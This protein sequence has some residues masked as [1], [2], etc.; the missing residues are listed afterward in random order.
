MSTARHLKHNRPTARHER[1]LARST[2]SNGKD[3]EIHGLPGANAA[4]HRH[5]F[6]VVFM[7]CHGAAC[8]AAKRVSSPLPLGLAT[9]S[10]NGSPH[11]RQLGDFCHFTD[12]TLREPDWITAGVARP[13]SGADEVAQ[14][15]PRGLCKRA[16]VAY[17]RGRGLSSWPPWAFC[18]P[19]A[20]LAKCGAGSWATGVA[21]AT[22][23]SP[24][25][26]SDLGA[27]R[28]LTFVFLTIVTSAAMLSIV[29]AAGQQ[30]KTHCRP[31]HCVVSLACLACVRKLA[32]VALACLVGMSLMG[33]VHAADHSCTSDA[34]CSYDGCAN[35]PCA[36][37]MLPH[38]SC[39]NGVWDHFCGDVRGSVSVCAHKYGSLEGYSCPEPS[40]CKKNHYSANG[41]DYLGD[42]ACQPCANGTYSSSGALSCSQS[43]STKADCD[44]SG[45]NNIQCTSDETSCIT[46][47]NSNLGLW[48]YD[49]AAVP[50]ANWLPICVYGHMYSEVYHGICPG[51]PLCAAGHYS[52]LAPSG[53]S[54]C[55]QCT[56]AAGSFCAA[57][58][59][60]AA[61]SVCPVG[62]YCLG[63][64]SDKQ[65]CT[66]AAGRFCPAGSSSAAGALCPAGH[67]CAGG[68]SDKQS[69]TTAPGSYCAA[70]S[71][72]AA[73]VLCPVGHFCVGGARDK[74]NCTAPV[75]SF[76]AE[77]SSSGYGKDCPNGHYCEGGVSDKRV[78]GYSCNSNA[79]CNYDGCSDVPC[80]SLSWHCDNGVR[81]VQCGSFGAKKYCYYYL[82]DT[83]YSEF[84]PKP[85]GAAGA[86]ITPAPA[87]TPRPTEPVTE[88]SQSQEC[89]F[90][91]ALPCTF[92]GTCG[93][94]FSADADGIL[95]RQGSCADQAGTLVLVNQGI[96]SLQPGVFGGMTKVTWISLAGNQLET[97]P[98]GIFKE[99]VALTQIWLY[100][101][102]LSS[103]PADIFSHIPQLTFLYLRAPCSTGAICG[104][105]NPELQCLPMTS[106]RRAALTTY[107]GP[108]CL[109]SNRNSNLQCPA[110]QYQSVCN[111]SSSG[112]CVTCGDCKAGD[113]LISRPAT[114]SPYHVKIKI[115]LPLPMAEFDDANQ[116]R[117]KDAIAKAAGQGTRADD[118]S[119][120]QLG[121]MSSARKLL[122]EGI[123]LDVIIWAAS[124]T[125]AENIAARLTEEKIKIELERAGFPG[126]TVLAAAGVREAEIDRVNA[127]V[128]VGA[129][130]GVVFLILVIVLLRLWQLRGRTIAHAIEQEEVDNRREYLE[131]KAL[132]EEACRELE[133]D[134][135]EPDNWDMI[136]ED[137]EDFE[138]H[139]AD[140]QERAVVTREESILRKFQQS[141]VLVFGQATDSTMGLAEYMCVTQQSLYTKLSRGDQAI[142]DEITDRSGLEEL[143]QTL[144]E[145]QKEIDEMHAKMPRPQASP[146]R[147]PAGVG[148]QP[149][150]PP[151]LAPSGLVHGEVHSDLLNRDDCSPE[152]RSTTGTADPGDCLP[153]SKNLEEYV[154]IL[155][156]KEQRV[157]ELQ[158]EIEVME[159]EIVATEECLNYVLHQEAGSS[160]KAYQN[161]WKLDCDKDSASGLHWKEAGRTV[162]T[163]GR[164]LANAELAE[165]LRHRSSF[166][167]REWDAF[168]IEDLRMDDYIKVGE[169]Y[170]RPAE[171]RGDVLDDRQVD[172]GRGGKRGMRLDDFVNHPVAVACGLTRQEVLAARLYTTTAYRR[173]NKPLR[174]LKR[175]ARHAPVPLPVTT[176]HLQEAV[177]KIRTMHARSERRND[178]VD[179]YRGMQD[180]HL[181]DAFLKNGGTELAPMSTSGDV[182]IAL[183]YDA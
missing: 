29:D 155:R 76:C 173:V 162:P 164:D 106:S 132:L 92:G 84:C 94:I 65:N 149:L 120:D 91:R 89:A 123:V 126:A 112:N 138:S 169:T 1:R 179:L 34:D 52:E 14:A 127:T 20:S 10:P 108:E 67:F 144:E 83:Q 139:S 81:R 66:A 58:S 48:K 96:K 51:P 6:L 27:G 140:A 99:T 118:V 64:A 61:G 151:P 37:A 107:H 180:V 147:P 119:I 152:S 159:E 128:I 12:L 104:S 28:I 24:N 22:S 5:R 181:E 109:C 59:S 160:D 134:F 88:C 142:V 161:G 82:P 183:R 49:C 73:G 167:Q 3:T 116:R 19:C 54:S 133:L 35:I 31:R 87:T 157:E 154:L 168:G 148:S 129:V 125:S 95:H 36:S 156:A 4:H 25:G 178:R 153:F 172:D 42:G 21:G 38:S 175:K 7:F 86:A 146:C 145:L 113:I 15:N 40:A 98:S 77:G 56:A 105:D 122:A 97:L 141:R 23:C 30:I 75:G 26:A 171:V 44:Y 114:S 166:E 101:N 131:L 63:G 74:Q 163:H 46:V 11:T 165:A 9:P 41:L 16:A 176:Q 72:S 137:Y 60:S 93:C 39:K 70:G 32:V 8:A 80:S 2:W 115:F 57:G 182:K 85:N 17:T 69:C 79:D 78:G 43:C 174:D 150:Q 130:A 13:G 143:K 135:D 177:R 121:K 102:Q 158:E 90:D 100:G 53:A 103:L 71:S 33:R 124:Q 117:F 62:Y 45:C 111:A 50:Q 170:F 110:G 47:S 136:V 55:S 68:A 18:V